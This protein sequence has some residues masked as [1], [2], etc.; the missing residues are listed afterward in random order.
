LAG[1]LEA[2]SEVGLRPVVLCAEDAEAVLHWYLL[3]MNG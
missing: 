1:D 2:L 3:R